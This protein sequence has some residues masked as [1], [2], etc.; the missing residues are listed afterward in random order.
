MKEEDE[1]AAKA[2]L[3]FLEFFVNEGLQEADMEKPKTKMIVLNDPIEEFVNTKTK[4][5]FVLHKN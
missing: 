3:K 5:R 4:R 2:F 1:E